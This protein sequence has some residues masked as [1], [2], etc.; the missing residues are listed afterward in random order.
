[1]ICGLF[2][3]RDRLIDLLA[4]DSDAKRLERVKENLQRISARNVKILCA[5]VSKT[6]AWWDGEPFDRVLLDVPCSATGVIRR[7]PDIKAL[8]RSSDIAMFARTQG[9]L[10]DALWPTLRPGGRLVYASCSVLAREND[11][12]IDAFLERTPDACANTDTFPRLPF[13]SATSQPIW[14]VSSTSSE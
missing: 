6:A 10:L 5:D 11:R 8:R 9:R 12:R 13:L 3:G 14:A 4:V 1:M 7:H 2:K